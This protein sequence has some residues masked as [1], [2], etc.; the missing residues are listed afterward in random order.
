MSSP[1]KALQR[2][3]QFG[4]GFC[5]LLYLVRNGVFKLFCSKVLY[6]QDFPGFP[7]PVKTLMHFR[8]TKLE[9]LSGRS[10][11]NHAKEQ[12]P[13]TLDPVGCQ[14]RKEHRLKR[15]QYYNPGPNAV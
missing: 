6:F 10:D 8:C 9:F 1:Y 11:L 7:G 13:Y 3:L 4:D 15:S 5:G 12:A 2:F 14:Q